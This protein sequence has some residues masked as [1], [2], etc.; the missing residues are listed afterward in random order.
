MTRR[1]LFR[2]KTLVAF[3]APSPELPYDSIVLNPCAVISAL[4]VLGDTP[5]MAM[6]WMDR[7][8]LAALFRANGGESWERKDNWDTDAELAEWCGVEV[9]HEG[10][11]V[12]IHLEH[13]NLRGT[14]WFVIPD[15][16]LSFG[17]CC[18]PIIDIFGQQCVV[19]QISNTATPHPQE[20]CFCTGI[21]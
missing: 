6:A 14:P 12:K 18:P 11:L 7:D 13:N 3:G 19:T 2:R 10:R 9:D 5:G 1:A 21:C 8:A 15:T 4:G 20:R 17:L 16:C